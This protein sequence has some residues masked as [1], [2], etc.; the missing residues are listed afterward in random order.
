MA[1]AEREPV[2]GVGGG[3]PSGV[4]GQTDLPPFSSYPDPYKNS[5]DLYQFQERPLAKDGWTCPPRGD[6]PVAIASLVCR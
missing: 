3:A 1:S 2:M 6:A 5:L 4:Q